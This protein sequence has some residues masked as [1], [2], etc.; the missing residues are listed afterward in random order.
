MKSRTGFVFF[1]AGAPISW[2]SQQQ[3]RT[4]KSSAEAEYMAL[5]T[6]GSEAIWL[7]RLNND[8]DPGLHTK[9]D[10]SPIPLFSDSQS[11]ISMTLNPKNAGR[12][13]DIDMHW[14]WIREQVEKKRIILH[15]VKGVENIADGL[16]KPLAFPQFKLFIA[17]LKLD[18]IHLDPSTPSSD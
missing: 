9:K 17:G 5:S 3:S 8:L 1:F 16:T 10:L 7:R 14:H 11:A 18:P 4:A 12:T 15:Y 2:K 13:K 6:A